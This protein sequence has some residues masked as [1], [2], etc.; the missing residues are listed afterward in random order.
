MD[1]RAFLATIGGV[2]AGAAG[3]TWGLQTPRVRIRKPLTPGPSIVRT[4]RTCRYGS[5]P[6]G[7]PWC[8]ACDDCQHWDGPM[9]RIPSPA[10]LKPP[11]WR[12]CDVIPDEHSVIA[13]W[14]DGESVIHIVHPA[15]RDTFDELVAQ[16]IEHIDDCPR[17]FGPMCTGPDT[18]LAERVIGR[19]EAFRAGGF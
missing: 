2:V 17:T 7:G 10:F 3:S 11:V 15:T 6:G 19:L 12:L 13:H 18:V 4:C 9:Y 8:L 16:M 14:T 1:R 5:V